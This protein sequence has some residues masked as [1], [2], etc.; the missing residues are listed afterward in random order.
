MI[1]KLT[2]PL[3]IGFLTLVVAAMMV[4]PWVGAVSTEPKTVFADSRCDQH[5]SHTHGYWFWQ[6]TDAYTSHGNGTGPY[7][8]YTHWADHENSSKDW[9]DS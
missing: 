7:G 4:L 6:R 9:C 8:Y 5:Y 2:L 1:P 3:R